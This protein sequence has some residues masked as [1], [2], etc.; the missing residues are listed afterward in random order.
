MILTALGSL[1]SSA[2]TGWSQRWKQGAQ[3]AGST[4]KNHPRSMQLSPRVKRGKRQREFK[5][6]RT[7]AE[8][9]RSR[10]DRNRHIN[11]GHC[12]ARKPATLRD[13]AVTSHGP[14]ISKWRFEKK[15][16]H[17]PTSRQPVPLGHL[18]ARSSSKNA[19][20]QQGVRG[21]TEAA[22]PGMARPKCR[23][24]VNLAPSIPYLRGASRGGGWLEPSTKF[25]GTR[26]GTRHQGKTTGEPVQQE[27]AR[28][29]WSRSPP[30]P[31]RVPAGL[32]K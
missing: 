15:Q 22:S 5:N 16:A 11:L 13:M 24:L 20:H 14:L 28:R 3:I 1:G 25:A 6:W 7:A 17:H 4:L 9:Q 26:N 8:A 12:R 31:V 29:S 23:A 19:T 10:P 27:Y 30:H 32:E 21:G 18:S 2:D